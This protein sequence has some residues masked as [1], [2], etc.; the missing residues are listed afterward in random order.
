MTIRA[1]GCSALILAAGLLVSFAGPSQVAAGSGD[2]SATSKSET[3]GVP[4]RHASGHWKNHA[5]RKVSRSAL[6]ASHSKKAASKEPAAEERDKSSAIPPSVA[7]A[8][9]QLISDDTPAGNAG[10]MSAQAN[11]ILQATPNGSTDVLPA[12]EAPLVSADR[13]N[14]V[15]RTLNDST[16][17]AASLTMA[18]A[19]APV[20]RAAPVAMMASS[21]EDST[22]DKTSLIGKIFIGFGALLTMA[23]AA[24]MFMA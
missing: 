3:A 13:L 4:S 16:P 21:D 14:D 6:K 9:A 2:T 15:D 19:E 24:R 11:E 1:R 20:E 7:N 17:P 12:G 23:S 8:K 22:W 18:S 5:H 10:T